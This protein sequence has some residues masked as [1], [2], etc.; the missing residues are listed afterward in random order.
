MKII[1]IPHLFTFAAR[2]T[3]KKENGSVGST[4]TELIREP[5]VKDRSMWDI[6]RYR[7]SLCYRAQNKGEVKE[8]QQKPSEPLTLQYKHSDGNIKKENAGIMGISEKIQCPHPEARHS[9]TSINTRFPL[10]RPG[11]EKTAR[12]K[13]LF[14]SFLLPVQDYGDNG[15]LHENPLDLELHRPPA[16]LTSPR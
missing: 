15:D 9:R 13:S 1:I 6:Q 3:L 4:L 16:R 11:P 7:T 10:C 14:G 2:L 5:T 12:Q 8:L